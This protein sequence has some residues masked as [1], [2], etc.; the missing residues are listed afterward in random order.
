MKY[1]ITLTVLFIFFSLSVFAQIANFNPIIVNNRVK[2]YLLISKFNDN[3]K[4]NNFEAIIYDENL[5]KTAS[6]NTTLP[7]YIFIRSLDFFENHFVYHFITVNGKE[8]LSYNY[9]G[10]PVKLKSIPSYEITQIT[11]RRSLSQIIEDYKFLSKSLEN[12]LVLEQVNPYDNSYQY[13]FQLRN[14]EGIIWTRNIPNINN[15]SITHPIS[16]K[17]VYDKDGKYWLFSKENKVGSSEYALYE[18]G[19]S[20]QTETLFGGLKLND[21]W[22]DLKV[23]DQQSSF[24]NNKLTFFIEEKNDNFKKQPLKFEAVQYFNSNNNFTNKSF[25]YFPQEIYATKNPYDAFIV[26]K[27]LNDKNPNIVLMVINDKEFGLVRNNIDLENPNSSQVDF[28]GVNSNVKLTDGS[29]NDINFYTT[30]NLDGSKSYLLQKTVGRKNHLFAITVKGNEV[31]TKKYYS[32]ESPDEISFL[33]TNNP[34]VILEVSF[35]KKLKGYRSKTINLNN[36]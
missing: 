4:V 12:K 20:I 26:E 34:Y 29:L 36:L 35:D 31:I 6:I 2:G 27:N 22:T 9:D 21:N 32:V 24:E 16:V 7:E 17:Y 3:N 19:K 23:L 30:H 18:I 15:L 10:T 33:P 11:T 25:N 8:Y 14:E 28:I 13:N 1:K 5:Q